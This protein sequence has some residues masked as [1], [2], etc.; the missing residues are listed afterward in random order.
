M[1]ASPQPIRVAD[2]EYYYSL[3][4]GDPKSTF[5]RGAFEEL[6]TLN[7][8]GLLIE[9]TLPNTTR[10]LMTFSSRAG[11]L[12][13]PGGETRVTGGLIS[14]SGDELSGYVFTPQERFA[15]LAAV[16]QTGRVQII[17]I[18]GTKLRYGSA[19][20]HNVAMGTELEEDE[21]ASE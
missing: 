3:R 13:E 14:R 18:V 8:S 15:E 19:L 5:D 9:P 6:A 2:W 10:G 21:I 1:E 12:H 17:R 7:F 4:G 11:M 16:A 20:I